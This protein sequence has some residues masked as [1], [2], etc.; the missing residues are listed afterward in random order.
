MLPPPRPF[1]GGLHQPYQQLHQPPLPPLPNPFWGVH[2][3][4]QPPPFVAP[5]AAPLPY[6]FQQPYFQNPRMGWQPGMLHARPPLLSMVPFPPP[7]PPPP[8]PL[9]PP[10]SPRP[11]IMLCHGS[12]SDFLAR[13]VEA[14]EGSKYVS[15]DVF[16]VSAVGEHVKLASG[17]WDMLGKV[18]LTVERETVISLWAHYMEAS[19]SSEQPSIG[20][21]GA[22]F[23]VERPKATSLTVNVRRY[24]PDA[25][26]G[27]VRARGFSLQNDGWVR[28]PADVLRAV[29]SAEVATGAALTLEGEIAWE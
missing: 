14:L 1:Y 26:G 23:Q 9:L 28:C 10:P 18:Y 29:H 12:L 27:L 21:E 4:Q 25:P 24:P 17:D 6:H 11:I 13:E 7:P 16:L 22:G 2:G 15:W 20:G 19:Q 3:Y 5:F 8:P